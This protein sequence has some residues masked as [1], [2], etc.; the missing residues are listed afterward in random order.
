MEIQERKQD[1]LENLHKRMTQ[2]T[3]PFFRKLRTV[4]MVVAAV[5]TSIIAAPVALPAALVTVGGYLIVG[6]SVI[7][8]VSQAAVG[9]KDCEM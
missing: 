8:A 3:P 1:A 6:G 7:S 4:G 5:G 9:E 2:E